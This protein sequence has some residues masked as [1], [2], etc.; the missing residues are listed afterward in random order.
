VDEKSSDL[1]RSRLHGLNQG[2]A[3]TG[4]LGHALLQLL[5]IVVAVRLVDLS[6]N[7][8]HAT[9]ST[10]FTRWCG[11]LTGRYLEGSFPH[12]GGKHPNLLKEPAHAERTIKH[13]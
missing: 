1:A 5:A 3:A 12:P 10:V 7:L 11:T 9:K 8:V 4:Q 13:G 2:Q 6:S